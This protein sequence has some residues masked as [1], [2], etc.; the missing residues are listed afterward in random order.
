MI[1]E[2]LRGLLD[3]LDGRRRR[4]RRLGTLLLSTFA[5]T[6]IYLEITGRRL[7]RGV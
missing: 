5:A 7:Q 6:V 1:F 4:Q 3:G 2:M